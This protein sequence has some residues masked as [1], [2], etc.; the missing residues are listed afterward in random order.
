MLMLSSQVKETIV[1]YG[2]V[3]IVEVIIIIVEVVVVIVVAVVVVVVVVELAPY[4]NML[5]FRCLCFHH[6]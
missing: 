4:Y 2:N 5:Y 1:L 3:I 6:R